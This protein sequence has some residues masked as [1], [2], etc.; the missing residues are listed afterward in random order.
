MLSVNVTINV[1]MF[2]TGNGTCGETS[3]F[4]SPC[5]CVSRRERRLATV[6][7]GRRETEW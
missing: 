2:V 5:F 1:T 3:L 6:L 7:I 4:I